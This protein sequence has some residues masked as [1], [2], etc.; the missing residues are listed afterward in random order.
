MISKSL[1]LSSFVEET[2][3]LTFPN[4]EKIHIKKPTQKLVFSLMAMQEVQN[5]KPEQQIEMLNEMVTMILSH[6]TEGKAYDIATVREFDIAIL[7]A[8]VTAYS[9]WIQ[10]IHANPN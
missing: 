8:I 10:E 1:D 9:G 5:E 2:F 6:N 4:K 3:E 7:M